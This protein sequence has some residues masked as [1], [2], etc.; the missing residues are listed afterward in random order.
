MT[1]VISCGIS[2]GICMFGMG[3][4]GLAIE[5][6]IDEMR[7]SMTIVAECLCYSL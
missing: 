5:R 3:E 4:S 7:G 2:L 1:A 6:V